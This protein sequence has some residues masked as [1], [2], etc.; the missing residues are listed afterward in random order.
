MK[1]LTSLFV[2]Q[3]RLFA[4]DILPYQFLVTPLGTSTFQK[5]LNFRNV[6]WAE[7]GDYMF[8]D[9]AIVHSDRTY[10]VPSVS[11]SQQRITL[12]VAGDSTAAHEA[13]EVIRAVLA[14]ASPALSES[15]PVLFTEE[16]F[17]AADLGFDWPALLNPAVVDAVRRLTDTPSDGVKF[18][19]K[20]VSVLFTLA[21]TFEDRTIN[22]Y[23]FSYSDK[24]VAV[25][26]RVNVPL[27]ARNYFT[28]SPLGSGA[29]LRF[30]EE[31][32][33]ELLV[34]R[35]TPRRKK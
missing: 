28:A 33:K 21:G 4:P 13:Y 27:A 8:Q 16:T 22:D 24:L 25:E 9:A 35:A 18:T 3:H 6:T 10:V 23:G 20:H 31:L 11:F 30:V 26:P 17:C 2:T 5:A 7:N 12:Q 14:Q 15:E 29:H 34:E 32:E 19:I 1:N